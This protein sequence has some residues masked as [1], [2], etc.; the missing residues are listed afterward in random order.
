MNTSPPTAIEMAREQCLLDLA[1]GSLSRNPY[2]RGCTERELYARAYYNERC[3]FTSAV[4]ALKGV[5]L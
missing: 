2:V 5:K 3:D 1:R 4:D